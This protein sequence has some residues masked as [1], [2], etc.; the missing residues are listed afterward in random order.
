[1]M[2]GKTLQDI[3]FIFIGVDIG[4]NIGA[5]GDGV[6]RYG[7]AVYL[8][9]AKTNRAVPSMWRIGDDIAQRPTNAADYF[10]T[11]GEQARKRFW[12]EFGHHVQQQY[13]VTNAAEYVSP[14]LEK[15]PL[16]TLGNIKMKELAPSDY[17]CINV[18]EWFAEN[19]S[20]YAMGRKDLLSKEFLNM[21]EGILK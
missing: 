4:E 5:M 11:E 9:T 20:L 12:H 21:M 3:P 19:F 1:M 18:R 8:G 17:A 13:G 15:K 16:A 10:E 2:N 7:D 6:L 14:V